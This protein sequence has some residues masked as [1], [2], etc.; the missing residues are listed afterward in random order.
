MYTYTHVTQELQVEYHEFIRLR[1]PMELAFKKDPTNRL[2]GTKEQSLTQAKPA[3]LVISF[4]RTYVKRKFS[5]NVHVGNATRVCTK[6]ESYNKYVCNINFN[7]W[8]YA[9]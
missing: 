4:S 2:S 8:Q 9:F 1:S 5:L 7:N 3:Y 6:C